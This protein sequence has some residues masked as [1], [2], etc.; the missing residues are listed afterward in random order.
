MYVGS[1]V[2]LLHTFKMHGLTE[3]TPQNFVSLKIYKWT[4]LS[5]DYISMEDNTLYPAFD[6]FIAYSKQLCTR[7]SACTHTNTM[8]TAQH[9]TQS[10]LPLA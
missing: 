5:K 7:L 1:A 4:R 9:A 10:F 2:A 6:G 3:L 8:H